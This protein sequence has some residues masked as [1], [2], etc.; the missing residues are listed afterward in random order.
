TLLVLGA[1]GGV[2]LTAV[3]VGKLMGARV[4]ACA[5]GADKLAI[6]QQAGADHLIDSSTADLRA[7]VKK[8]GGADVVYDPVGGELF[9][10]AFRACNPEAR[11]LTIGFASGEVPKILANHLL[12][13]NISVLGFYWGGYM[14]F[15]PEVIIQSLTELISWYSD[16]KITPHISHTLPLEQAAEGMELLRS[17]KSTGKVV[18]TV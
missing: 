18:I 3:E 7:E 2:G 17:R 15:K 5:R 1:A 12:V 6:A 13:K 10:A 14:N 8:L 4:M 9:E 16:G 11:I